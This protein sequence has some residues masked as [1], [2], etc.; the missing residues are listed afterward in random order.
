MLSIELFLSSC[1]A[2][3]F[4]YFY[5]SSNTPSVRTDLEATFTFNDVEA[6]SKKLSIR[7]FGEILENINII[8]PIG[9]KNHTIVQE[10]IVNDLRNYGWYVDLDTFSESTVVG[11]KTFTNILA[12]NDPRASRRLVLSCHYE[13]KLLKG[14]Y[15]TIDSA[16]PCSIIVNIGES[17]IKLFNFSKFDVAVQ[18]IFFDGEEAFKEWT[19]TDSIY[20]SRHLAAKMSLTDSYGCSDIE[21]IDLFILL[22]LIGAA[23]H[24]FPRYSHCDPRYYDMLYEIER[25]S[26]PL[27]LPMS[28]GL[29]ASPYPSYFSTASYSGIEDDHIP[30]LKR[31]VPV[32]H[33]IPA[34]FPPQWHRVTDT[35]DNIDWKAI[36]D[37]QLMVAAFL[38]QYLQVSPRL[39]DESFSQL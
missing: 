34:P 38:C 23:G 18:L 6:L 32:L 2:L 28:H 20:G 10:F 36:H 1:L 29:G 8:R 17:L 3:A 33:L 13:S 4:F 30:F 16:V 19:A 27:F 7:R 5:I 25:I 12:I 37:I 22:D 35:I 24:P 26:E 21:K 11:D 9:S 31:G 14:F 15:G 39:L